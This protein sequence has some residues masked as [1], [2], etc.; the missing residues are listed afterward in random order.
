MVLGWQGCFVWTDDALGRGK[1]GYSGGSSD[2]GKDNG[3]GSRQHETDGAVMTT[4]VDVL[5]LG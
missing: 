4:S 1:G 3:A 5:F 2:N